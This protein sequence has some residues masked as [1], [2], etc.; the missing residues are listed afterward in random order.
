MLK[1]TENFIK[2]RK[3]FVGNL[4]LKLIPV[5]VPVGGGTLNACYMNAHS[6]K[7][8]AQRIGK[9]V[10]IVSG[11]IVNEYDETNKCVSIIAHWW[12]RDVKTNSNFDTTPL[13]INGKYEYVQDSEI[14]MFC[15][16]NDSRLDIHQHYSL[17]FIDGH[18]EVLVDEVNFKFKKIDSLKT[19]NFYNLN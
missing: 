6:A 10:A 2:D 18:Y 8:D 11:W 4:D 9:H 5:V 19:E 13:T 3:P 14:F 16:K 17:S 15:V 7:E 1:E 12:N